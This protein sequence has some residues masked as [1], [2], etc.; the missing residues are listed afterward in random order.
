M[1]ELV[2]ENEERVES[3]YDRVRVR[4]I[5]FVP[6]VHVSTDMYALSQE[7][8]ITRSLRYSYED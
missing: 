2:L 6:V 5:R 3:Q 8:I 4:Q 7:R 1:M